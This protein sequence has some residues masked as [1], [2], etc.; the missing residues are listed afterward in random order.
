MDVAT[1]EGRRAFI[2]LLVAWSLCDDSQLGRD[3]TM[4]YMRDKGCWWIDC[5]DD[6]YDGGDIGSTGTSTSNDSAGARSSKMERYYFNTT[7]CLADRLFGRHTRCFPA[8]KDCPAEKIPS[9]ESLKATVVIKD[10]WAYAKREASEDSRDEVKS[11]KKIQATFKAKNRQDI[12]YPKIEVG[13]RVKIKRR[14]E[15][16]E[17]TTLTIYDGCDSALL[18][19]VASDILFRAHRRIAMSTIG[20]P[21]R[22]VRNVKEFVTVLHDAMQCHYTI[23]KHCR[24]LHRDISENNVLVVR[25]EDGAVRGLL[26]DFDC[27]INI[28]EE[29]TGARGEMTGTYPFMSL[30]NLSRSEVKRTSLDDWESMLYLLCLYATVGLEKGNERSREELAELPIARWRKDDIGSVT[31]AKK[32]HLSSADVFEEQIVRHFN[33]KDRFVEQLRALATLLY[34]TLFENEDAG[35]LC[36]GTSK[37]T[38]GSSAGSKQAMRAKLSSKVPPPMLA[39]STSS[40]SSDPFEM[41]A[42]QWELISRQLLEAMTIAKSGMDT[43]EDIAT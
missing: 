43:W 19:V 23:V 33:D 37:H 4:G 13:G 40:N 42:Q 7:I 3:P 27:A 38:S 24:I 11:M 28:D 29:K 35:P 25:Q 31:H 15:L 18:D 17:D 1:S 12:L 41:R 5:S 26:I 6:G 9:G 16:V 20:E 39:G 32:V 2:R 10:A 34:M 30:N 8:T 21:L 36:Y 22:K 14:G